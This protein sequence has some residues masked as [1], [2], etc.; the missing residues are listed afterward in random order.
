[1][2][3]LLLLVGGLVQPDAR[4]LVFEPLDFLL[5][6]E[7]SRGVVLLHLIQFHAHLAQLLVGFVQLLRAVGH[8]G[9][10]VQ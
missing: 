3:G 7:N 5:V 6:L 8:G 2:P 10:A 1:M 9:R 4:Q